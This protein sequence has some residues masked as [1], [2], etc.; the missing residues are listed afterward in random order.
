MKLA[1]DKSWWWQVMLGRLVFTTREWGA[2]IGDNN[3]EWVRIVP[4]VYWLEI[5]LRGAK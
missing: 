4:C 3:G 5:D 2:A 1:Q